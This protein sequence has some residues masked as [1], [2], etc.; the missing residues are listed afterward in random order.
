MPQSD[1]SWDKNQSWFP[2][3]C[4]TLL[5]PLSMGLEV[6][7]GVLSKSACLRTLSTSTIK[8]TP[9]QMLT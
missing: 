7:I 2:A 5:D 3:M 8:A 9:D 1:A 6:A 4:P